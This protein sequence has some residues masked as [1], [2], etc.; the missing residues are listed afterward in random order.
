[1]MFK[2]FTFDLILQEHAGSK[3]SNPQDG[4]NMFCRTAGNAI[5]H[6]ISRCRN[7]Q[8]K[9]Q[10]FYGVVVADV[11]VDIRKLNFVT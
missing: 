5:Q 3:I 7:C 11:E 6:T 1:M 8:E 2:A 10:G 4:S 9:H